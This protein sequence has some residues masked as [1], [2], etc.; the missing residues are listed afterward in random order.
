MWFC[1]FFLCVQK[2]SFWFLSKKILVTRTLKYFS[3]INHLVWQYQC[4]FVN[5]ILN[6]QKMYVS[7]MLF[8]FARIFFFSLVCRAPSKTLKLLFGLMFKRT[9]SHSWNMHLFFYKFKI[10]F[11]KMPD[12]VKKGYFSLKSIA[13]FL[14]QKVLSWWKSKNQVFGLEKLQKTTKI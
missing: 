5:Q 9:F 4:V 8:C 6:F 3:V 1:G 10:L 13:K 12:I 7:W 14:L 11:R 2:L